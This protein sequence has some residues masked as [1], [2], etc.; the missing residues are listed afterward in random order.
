MA[1]LDLFY[2]GA[3]L[4]PHGSC[5]LWWPELL[6]AHVVTDGLIALAY[7]S[8]PGALAVLT[9]RRRDLVVR[10]VFWMFAAFI[11]A[12]GSTHAISVWTL[13]QPVYG[14]EIAVK[15]VTAVVS[16]ATA[17]ALW[18]LLPHA[19]KLPSAGDLMIAN[20]RLG[21]E[22]TERQVA[23]AR[24][25]ALNDELESRVAARTAELEGAVQ[26]LERARRHLTTLHRR[27][28]EAVE[29]LPGGFA[30]FDVEDR[31]VFAN[32][33]FRDVPGEPLTVT[34]GTCFE[35]IATTAADRLI[36]PDE[37]PEGPAAWVAWR[38][39]RHRDPG[40]P[41]DLRGRDGRWNRIIERR[42]AEGGVVHLRVDITETKRAEQDLVQARTSAEA[43]NRAKSVFLARM[44]HELRTPMNAILGFAEIMAREMFGQMGSPRYRRYAADI[45]SSGQ[46]LLQLINDL[47]DIGRIETGKFEI[48]P[49]TIDLAE[50]CGA[51]V[52]LI[53]PTGSARGV[54]L[55]QRY[56]P[57]PVVQADLRA[58]RQIL[59]NLLSNAVK[60]TPSGGRIVVAVR[61]GGDVVEVAVSDDG[62]GIP[63]AVLA[64]IGEPFI[65]GSSGA[66]GAGLGLAISRALAE[67]HGGTLTIESVVGAGTTATVRLPVGGSDGTG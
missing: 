23:E 15:A 2:G 33:A 21:E 28:V 49:E 38:V 58:V 50:L 62:P 20:R 1:V 9:W 63:A 18:P 43:A 5:L 48:R 12:C 37:M 4:L 8:I 17:A 32:G 14:L 46:H 56:E 52:R 42:T 53:E 35:E 36:H 47:L 45:L 19:L 61:P 66:E 54:G 57:A 31:L 7:F 16:V 25:R 64:R 29:N 51:T 13:W 11:L 65:Q 34:E 39:A 44:S 67:R 55:E 6:V 22:V 26:E 59:F 3:G 41:L 30:L 27:F 10:P 24:L 60:F 40:R